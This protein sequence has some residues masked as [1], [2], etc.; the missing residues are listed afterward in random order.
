MDNDLSRRETSRGIFKYVIRNRDDR[1]LLAAHMKQTVIVAFNNI[2]ISCDKLRHELPYLNEAL[3]LLGKELHGTIL[4]RRKHIQETLY[5]FFYL[6]EEI[7]HYS[8][9]VHL[10][11]ADPLRRNS[12]KERSLGKAM[13][14]ITG[15][16]N[17]QTSQRLN[18]SEEQALRTLNVLPEMIVLYL[19][20]KRINPVFHATFEG[21][22]YKPAA[23]QKDQTVHQLRLALLNQFSP[24]L[25]FAYRE[26]GSL[27]EEAELLATTAEDE[28][29]IEQVT[30]DYY[31]HIFDA[32]KSLKTS[33]DFAQKEAVATESLKQFKII[34]LGLHKIIESTIVNNM[35]AMKSQTN[36]LRSK[37]LGPQSLSLSQN[38]IELTVDSSVE[39][40]QRL[41][42]ELY[43]RHVAPQLEQYRL[44]Y[45]TKVATMQAVFD[46]E[47]RKLGLKNFQ[48]GG[49]IKQLEERIEELRV[50]NYSLEHRLARDSYNAT[51]ND[52]PPY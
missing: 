13:K 1:Q 35:D 52:L 17:E 24:E 16:L 40:A 18:S 51:T 10:D 42:E 27:L 9:E 47:A 48:N 2:P 23:P 41:R 21:Q 44:E 3:D 36:F 43:M 49:V 22:Y 12:N 4:I 33:A 30:K 19:N 11:P 20:L 32:L 25:V 37:V 14:K 46:E 50:E 28:Y 39:E 38:E 29:F 7:L 45:E 15:Q 8:V 26:A 34:Q 5:Q 31:T 6:M